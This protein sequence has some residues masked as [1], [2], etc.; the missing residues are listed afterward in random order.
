MH[1]PHT[2]N[3]RDY[4]APGTGF[5]SL[6]GWT[7]LLIVGPLTI[8]ATLAGTMGLA[9]IGW[10][11]AAILY[12]SRIR[13]ARARL[14]GSSLRVGPGQFPEI[15]ACAEEIAL[16]MGVN[17]PEVY[18]T[19][20]NQQNAF[21]IKKGSQQYVV[22]MDDIVHG[23]L[24]TGNPDVIRFILAHEI[25]HH[26]LGHTSTLRSWITR[27]YHPLSRLDEFSCDAIAQALVVDPVSSRDALT[28]LLVGPQLYSKVNRRSLDA[29]AADVMADKR[30]KK[31]ESGLTHPLLLRRYARLMELA[32]EA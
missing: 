7:F 24:A 2:I 28:L 5:H 13:K 11:V 1:P 29:Q 26:A 16:A 21:A 9:L 10:L 32:R 27:N 23:A 25:A 12:Y 20:D 19:E 22:L 15:H 31:A 14:I 4:V 18:I 30:S 8:A 3:P 6:V 17:L